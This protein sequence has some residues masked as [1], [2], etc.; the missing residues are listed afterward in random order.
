MAAISLTG[1]SPSIAQTPL[2]EQQLVTD[3]SRDSAFDS[4]CHILIKRRILFVPAGAWTGTAVLYKGRYLLTAGHNVYQDR[5]SIASISVRCGAAEPAGLPVHEVVANWQML[6]AT[7]YTGKGFARD[8]GVIRLN[9]PLAVRQPFALSE[10]APALGAPLRFAGY[11]GEGETYHIPLH[12]G[13]H[14]HSAKGRANAIE[15]SILSYDIR[16]FKSNSGGPVWTEVNGVPNLVAIHVQPS[17]GRLVD[18]DYVAE[19]GRLMDK[20]DKRAAARGF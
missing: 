18:V 9:R 5:S 12:D 8:F 11:P 20:L 6:D 2:I 16:T 7:G 13:W 15:P 3:A 17:A 1:I 4:V 14:L 10:T 19:V